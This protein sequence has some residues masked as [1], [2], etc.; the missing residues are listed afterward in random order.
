MRS[1]PLTPPWF[2]TPANRAFARAK[3]VLDEA[4]LKLIELRRRAEVPSSDLMSLLLA[5]RDE[6]GGGMTDRQ[7]KDEV[8]TLLT[9]GH[10]TTSSALSWAWYLLGQHPQVQDDLADE[11]R[12]RGDAGLTAD[13][14]PHLPLARAVF[15]ETMRL[16]P[17]A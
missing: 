5:A 13:D 8:L 16:Y 3:K 14:L 6:A 15:E 2:P 1:P 10:E 7:V 17:P 11:A 12:G 4:V 9:A